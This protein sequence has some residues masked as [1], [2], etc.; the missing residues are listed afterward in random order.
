M[1]VESRCFFSTKDASSD[2]GASSTGGAR[3]D[4][5]SGSNCDEED[6]SSLVCQEVNLHRSEEIPSLLM[7]NG[8]FLNFHT[9]EAEE[10]YLQTNNNRRYQRGLNSSTYF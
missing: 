10:S 3:R 4:A 2:N 6:D 1:S 7:E 9:E 5:Q 8:Q